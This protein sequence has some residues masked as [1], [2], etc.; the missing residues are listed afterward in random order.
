MKTIFAFGFA[1]LLS[2]TVALATEAKHKP[3]FVGI[4]SE[5]R[6]LQALDAGGSVLFRAS[7]QSGANCGV[8]RA[9]S[10]LGSRGELVGYSCA[11]ASAN[12]G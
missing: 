8:D 12:G 6:D 2:T 10:V 4:Q 11:T 1:T 5:S 3:P 9:E 7:L